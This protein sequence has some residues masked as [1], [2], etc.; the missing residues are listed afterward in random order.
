MCKLHSFID[1]Q[2]SPC[3]LHI[4][5]LRAAT[6]A[7]THAS[8]NDPSWSKQI[9]S[10]W[11]THA[12]CSDAMHK[13]LRSTHPELVSVSAIKLLDTCAS[14]LGG[15]GRNLGEQSGGSSTFGTRYPKLGSSAFGVANS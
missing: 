13:S 12:K 2:V 15:P 3:C 10:Q 4:P 9:K 7:M 5:V 6:S 14:S 1:T 11:R 8:N